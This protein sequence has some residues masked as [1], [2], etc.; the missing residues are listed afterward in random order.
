VRKQRVHPG[1]RQLLLG[2]VIAR[3]RR[4]E[5]RRLHV[6]KRAPPKVAALVHR[7]GDRRCEAWWRLRSSPSSVG[8]SWRTSALLGVCPRGYHRDDCIALYP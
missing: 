3:G 2:P 1:R 5:Q 6:L 4:R 8:S 7:C